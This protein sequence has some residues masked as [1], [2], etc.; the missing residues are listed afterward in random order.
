VQQEISDNAAG[1]ATLY[2]VPATAPNSVT[3]NPRVVSIPTP[4]D[5]LGSGGALTGNVFNI[6]TLTGST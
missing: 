1:V 3:K 4:V 5:L 6:T 2:N